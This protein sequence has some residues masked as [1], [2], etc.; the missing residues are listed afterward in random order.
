MTH[1]FRRSRLVDDVAVIPKLTKN[2]G[3]APKI[4]HE[5]LPFWLV[6]VATIGMT[7]PCSYPALS[8]L[9]IHMRAL[10]YEVGEDEP[11]T[12]ALGYWQPLQIV[13]EETVCTVECDQIEPGRL[14]GSW[15]WHELLEK[16]E[17]SGADA[18]RTGTLGNGAAGEIEQMI[19]F[20]LG[21]SQCASDREENLV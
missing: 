17:V 12:I 10:P 6:M 3:D 16:R 9:Y 2:G 4:G 8:M 14:D 7:Q 19:A 18:A 5:L 13:K 20:I 21:E 15:Q 1:A 11:C